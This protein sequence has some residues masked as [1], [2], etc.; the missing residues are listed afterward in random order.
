MS[1]IDIIFD[2]TIEDFN[3]FP[4]AQTCDELFDIFCSIFAEGCKRTSR[5]VTFDDILFVKSRLKKCNVMCTIDT[6]SYEDPMHFPLTLF[7]KLP[8]DKL[9]DCILQVLGDAV[10]HIKFFPQFQPL[11][12]ITPGY[13]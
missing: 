6:H 10:Y 8:N 1:I 2:P 7:M 11:P 13:F 12:R 4:Q 9:Q 5:K 3:F